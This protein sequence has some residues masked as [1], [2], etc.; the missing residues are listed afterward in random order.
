MKARIEIDGNVEFNGSTD[1]WAAKT[2]DM[3]KD[4]IKPNAAPKPWLKAI[5]VEFADSVNQKRSVDVT[6]NTRSYGWDMAV[7]YE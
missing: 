4:V 3:F 6:V 2:P 1:E 5:L 7:R